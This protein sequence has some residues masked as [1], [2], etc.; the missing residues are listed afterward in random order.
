[1]RIDSDH[2]SIWDDIFAPE[3]DGV[4]VEP[5]PAAHQLTLS[6]IE[7]HYVHC[8]IDEGDTYSHF[9]RKNVFIGLQ[10]K[11]TSLEAE[12][13]ALKEKNASL[14]QQ[15]FGPSSEKSLGASP[16]TPQVAEAEPDVP[17]GNVIE[18]IKEKKPSAAGRKPLP[19][20]LP[21]EEELHEASRCPCCHGNKLH[22]IDAEVTEQMTIVPA[23][24]RVIRHMRQKYSCREC[25][26]VFTADGVKHLIEKSSY[27][28]PELLAH[29][30]CSKYQFGLPFYRQ[31]TVF[32]QAGHRIS[33]TTLANLMNA[34]GD[35]L[36]AV[37]EML[38]QDLLEQ[39][40]VHADET[41]LQVLKELN[42]RAQIQS[43]LWLYR[44]GEYAKRQI[45]LFDYQQTRS[46]N[47]P[48]RFLGIDGDRPFRGHLHTDAWQGYGEYPDVSHGYC[49]SHARRRFT[50][51]I[52]ILPNKAS[53]T[54]AHHAVDLFG[55]LY[56]IERRIKGLSDRERYKIR[57]KESVPIL[58]ELKIWL[59]EMQPK[60]TGDSKLGKAIAYT[61]QNWEK[62]SYYVKD[63][64]W[65]IDNNIAEREIKAVVIGRKNWLFSDSVEGAHTI[66]IMY[67]LVATARANGVDLYKYLTY[68]IK[69]MPMLRTVE[70]A[71]VLLPWN[72]PQESLAED[73]IAA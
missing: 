50:D 42:R 14:T 47:H 20:H 54:P 55:K 27:A 73:S 68:V 46:G 59:D 38:R 40:V 63:G 58:A 30:A 6:Y 65:P 18:P 70:E 1:M 12:L 71:K 43:W 41:R 64:R 29:I 7:N 51:A 15:L 25:F 60:V 23:H 4:R 24:L 28:T 45:V 34:C 49:M 56:E 2:S 22:E 57:Q 9:V 48:R 19:D 52:K 33:R 37:W 61:V 39:S 5:G 66:A 67:S 69:T 31:E 53:G 17:A 3:A 72:M 16:E 26:T 32:E 62:L 11:V 8:I 44:S 36:F 21:R 35:K 13:T 10:D